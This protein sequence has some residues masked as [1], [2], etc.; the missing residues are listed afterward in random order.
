MV[1]G[2]EKVVPN[3]KYV[4]S[5]FTSNTKEPVE[6]DL[7]L[8]DKDESKDI[9]AQSHKIRLDPSK[10]Q[11]IEF[12]IKNYDKPNLVLDVDAT[13]GGKNYTNSMRIHYNPKFVSTFIQ[14]DKA[15]YK[16]GM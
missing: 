10:S 3:S 2:S 11:L 6:I 5:A 7:K 9:P 13:F 8:H 1:V 12:D 4:V 14:T 15:L 16:A